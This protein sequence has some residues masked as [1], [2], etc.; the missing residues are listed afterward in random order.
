[1]QINAYL[2]LFL[3]SYPQSPETNVNIN[4]SEGQI[5]KICLHLKIYLNNIV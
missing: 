4:A 1:M 3:K 5:K 2:I